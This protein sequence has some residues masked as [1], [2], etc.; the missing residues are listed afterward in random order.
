MIAT[1]LTG[2]TSVEK[3]M[4]QKYVFFLRRAIT[5]DSKQGTDDGLNDD[6]YE[7]ISA[8]FS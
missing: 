3:E 2:A 4:E 7:W 8:R 1:A 5:A 6:D